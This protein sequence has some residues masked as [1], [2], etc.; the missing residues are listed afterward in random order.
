MDLAA[1]TPMMQQYLRI[2]ARYPD[3]LLFYRMG[4]FYELFYDDAKR[5][6]TLLDIT[7][8][9]RG[10]S[11]GSPIPMAGVPFHAVDGYLAKLV[12]AGQAVAI[13]EQIGDPATT[14]GPVE[15]QV[16]RVVTPGT[17]AED[18]LL[19]PE[20]DSVL[21]GVNPAPTGYGV[22]WL[23]LASGE[24]S[25]SDAAGQT[26][27][28]ALLAR[29]RPAE[30]LVPGELEVDPE[31]AV[32]RRD[33][34]EFDNGLGLRHLTDHFRVADLGAFGLEPSDAAVGAASAVL[35]YAQ[36]ARCQTLGFVDR[37]N[38]VAEA[39]TVVMDAQTRRNL[40]IDRRLDGDATGTLFS[41]MNHT[42]TAMGARL[43]K[44]WLNA[45]VRDHET[46]TRR[47]AAVAAIRDS[48]AAAELTSVLSDIGDME[49]ITS[50]IGLG[51]ASPRDLGRLRLALRSM[52]HAH[53]LVGDLA[54][55][56]LAARFAGLP[57]FDPEC[58]ELAGALVDDPPA[59]IRDGGVFARGYDAEL[60]RLK[61]L[62]ENA[63][64]W[65]ADLESRERQRTGI[66]NLKVGYNRV[67][68]Y[69]IEAGRAVA[70][71]MPAE[72]V[73]RQTLKNAERYIMPE[74]KRFE[75]EALTSQAQALRRERALF[76]ILI[77]KLQRGLDGLRAAAREL[78]RLDVL[79]AFAIAADRHRFERPVLTDEPVLVVE[80]GRH[81]V[82]EAES[83]E[84]FVPNDLA[85]SDT[86]RMLIVTG[87]NMGGKSTYMRQAALITLLAHTGSFVPATAARIGPIDRIFTRIGASD[88][89]ARGRSTF[90]VEMS[91]TAHILHNATAHSLVLLD[92]IGR[93]TSTYDGLALAWATADHIARAIGAFTLFATHYFELTALPAEIDSAANVHL[94]AVE[95]QGEVVFLHSVREGPASQS[96][97]IEVAKLAG[98]P[99][100]VLADA[101]RRLTELEKRHRE[102]GVS[103][104]MDLFQ[105]LLADVD[106][107]ASANPAPAVMQ[108]LEELDPD[109][110]SP[111][112]A[113]AVLYDLKEAAG[114][115]ASGSDPTPNRNPER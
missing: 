101:R 28:A 8:T 45:P 106:G 22:A 53:R 37:L 38:H 9:A 31:L 114:G 102:A 103:P 36:A 104:Q 24:F 55:R 70:T 79:A 95:H 74:L 112:D 47:Q 115:G 100:A 86:R 113:H 51:N 72:Y 54:D 10:Q 20:R 42:A 90:M 77:A 108:R 78:A 80:G 60:D 82:V 26:E 84:P 97:G 12:E 99:G 91:E 15:R 44:S 61:D 5:A 85:L 89:L 105:D 111:R 33:G 50:R 7:L 48:G 83:V 19:A 41:V 52:P 46:L 87:P 93:G 34:L 71:E 27:L 68:G 6:A 13:C 98:V 11:A 2:K 23:N 69:Y 56:D 14:R 18:G 96:Y 25:F 110:L 32:Q 40:E 88:D 4:D 17:L 39:E 92:E 16:Q 49:R 63:A 65:L 35:R 29:L 43:L 75:D 76:D 67:H 107:S 30:V 66:A 94:D 81:P 62:T 21:A 1:H 59:T 73:R 109:S 3:T 57:S 58:K 64:D